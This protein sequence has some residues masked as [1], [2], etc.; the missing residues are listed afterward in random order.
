MP[1][2][3][4]RV[5]LDAHLTQVGR[6]SVRL[7]G[8]R[9]RAEQLK[10]ALETDKAQP[11]AP[12]DR[13][14]RHNLAAAVSRAQS[15]GDVVGQSSDM[16]R[17]IRELERKLDQALSD[18]A[19]SSAEALLVVLGRFDSEIALAKQDLVYRRT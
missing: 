4:D 18:L 10:Q 3:A 11:C 19:V 2:A 12:T 5:A 6:L 14:M 8:Y 13:A 16:E 15:L 9:E 1:S 17:Q 7:D